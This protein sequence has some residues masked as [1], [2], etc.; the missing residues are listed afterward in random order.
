M[1]FDHLADFAR[2]QKQTPVRIP[3]IQAKTKCSHIG[4]YN[5]SCDCPWYMCKA[6]GWRYEIEQQQRRS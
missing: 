4:T 6:T 1:Y 5:V 2:E 3:L